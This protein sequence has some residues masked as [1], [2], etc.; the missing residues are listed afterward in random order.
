MSHPPLS[1]PVQRLA[2]LTGQSPES[3][4]LD[5]LEMIGQPAS[6][7]NPP[8]INL[9]QLAQLIGKTPKSILADRSRAPHRVPPACT[10]PG[11]RTPLWITAEVV[12]WVA[13][14]REPADRMHKT[15]APVEPGSRRRGRPK[16]AEQIARR[17]PASAAKGAG[18]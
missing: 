11:T 17:E 13:Q 12:A 3:V 6:L 8:V 18:K 16:K 5:L 7:A 2:A 10:A 4:I 14:H 15:I 1:A 9:D